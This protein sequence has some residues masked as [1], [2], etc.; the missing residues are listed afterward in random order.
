MC[1]KI[2]VKP[3][4]ILNIRCF[5]LFISLF[6][7]LKPS[8]NKNVTGFYKNNLFR[9]LYK[10]I[11]SLLKSDN[12]KISYVVIRLFIS[13]IRFVRGFVFMKFLSLS[14]L[15][16]ITLVMAVMGIF[17]LLQIGLL[18]GGYRIFSV[19]NPNKWRVNDTIYSY[20]SI[21]GI[22]ISVGISIAYLLDFLT[23]TELFFSFSATVF[24]FLLVLNNWNRNILI[25]HQKLKEI[26]RIEI[27]ATI[28]SLLMLF[29]VYYLKVYG[30]LIVIFSRELIF[31]TLTIIKNKNYLPQQFTFQIKEVKW[32]LSFGFLPFL[33]GMVTNMNLQ[34]ETWSIA[35]FLSTEALGSFYLPKLYIS[36]FMI[37]PLAISKL[38]FPETMRAF[39]KGDFKTVK[40]II[41]KYFLINIGFSI[42]A[43]IATWLFLEMI[44][45]MAIPKHL[46][47]IK[48]VWLVLPGLVF[49]V[50]FQPVNLIFNAA[51][52][53]YPFL[54]ASGAALALTVLTVPIV[55]LF[56]ELT[57][58]FVAIIKCLSYII[59][60]SVLLTIFISL[61]KKIWKVNRSLEEM[62]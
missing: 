22:I 15:G 23:A 60:S 11:L 30:A 36:L 55:G 32:I 9:F 43:V 18:N 19:D 10:K 57:L 56:G 45:G 41:K 17:R 31:Y 27:T 42:F 26:N 29:S 59:T 12:S 13:M 61:R 35:S 38:F 37:I 52:K 39:V 53:L 50:I 3:I 47:G 34:V 48:Y 25:A 20:F 6:L 40:N 28:L 51:V 7:N 33:A 46:I 49:Y 5:Q 16:I 1:F 24:G 14:E 54:W 8:Q 58:N 21:V 2:I 44:I 62:P 4:A